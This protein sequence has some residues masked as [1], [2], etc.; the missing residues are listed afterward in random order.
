MAGANEDAVVRVVA[1][2]M[3]EKRIFVVRERQVMLDEDLADLYEVETK[4][5]AQQV[6]PNLKPFRVR[7]DL[8]ITNGH[9]RVKTR[10]PLHFLLS[11]LGALELPH[12]SF[13]D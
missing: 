6:K 9:S 2:P 1:A 5:L 13:G 4:R 12:S 8:E 3:I 7:G 10:W 11:S